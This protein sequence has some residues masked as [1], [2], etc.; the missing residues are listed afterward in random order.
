[1]CGLLLLLTP[2]LAAL[3]AGASAF[4]AMTFRFW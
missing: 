1:V 2:L 4:E 3:L